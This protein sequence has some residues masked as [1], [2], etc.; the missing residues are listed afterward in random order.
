[1]APLQVAVLDDYKGHAVPIFA[2]LDPS[3]FA[4]TH[5]PDTLLPYNGAG[6]PQ[7]E[8]DRLVALL[9]P[10]EVICTWGPMRSRCRE[11]A[12]GMHH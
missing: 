10:F 5:L 1:M 8:K 6:T 9:E 2:A 12:V 11:P 3:A 4:V 7:A